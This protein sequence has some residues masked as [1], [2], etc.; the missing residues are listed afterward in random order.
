MS[1]NPHSGA[2]HAGH[3]CSGQSTST[4]LV[5]VSAALMA[6]GLVM[7]TSAT[8]PLNG[9]LTVDGFFRTVFGRHAIFVPLA[10]VL[11]LVVSR[12]GYFFWDSGWL[13]R[14]L[15]PLLF[16][17]AVVGLL[18]TMLLGTGDSEN[19]SARWLRFVAQGVRVGYQPSE[20]AKP[21]LVM[22]LAW[23]VAVRQ[24]DPRSFRR[25][26]L[27]ASAAI[28]LTVALVGLEDLG[29]A[30]LI[31]G[32]G[33]VML[34]VVGC[35]VRHLL[36][37]A[38]AGVALLVGLLVAAP[39]RMVRITSFLDIWGD[40]QGAGYQPLQ[41]LAAINAGHWL[42]TGLGAG[43]QKYGYLP[44]SHSDFIF[45]TI[46]EEAGTV[47]GWAVIAL[48][49]WLMWLGWRIVR[50]APAAFERLVAFGIVVTL[51]G[52]AV[53][54]IAVVTVSTPTTGISLP[55]VSAG[56]SGLLTF[57]CAIGLLA[58]VARRGLSAD[59]GLPAMPPSDSFN[60]SNQTY[61]TV[62]VGE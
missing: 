9:S 44:E 25:F 50:E 31:A 36:L 29:T 51:G 34:I 17:V 16:V 2:P 60:F 45:A 3:S 7:V 14:R 42:G 49:C 26:F 54:N 5:L 10:V 58:S 20:L 35:R 8:A 15:P 48:F 37:A 28:G 6:V 11:M 55:L 38:S 30:V 57:G 39:Y 56:G 61:A 22:F 33:A 24:C 40:A 18:G 32:V 53:M 52:Q 4:S 27:P 43:I 23:M 46:C 1:S 13:R 62:G 59:A 47:G 12:Y 19:T 21:A 41:S